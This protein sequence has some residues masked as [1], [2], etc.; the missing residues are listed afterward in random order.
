MLDVMTNTRRATIG[1]PREFDVDEALERAMVVFWEQGYEGASLTDLTAAMGITRTS[2]YAAFGN[3]EGLFRKA[4]DRYSAGPAGYVARALEEPTA[5]EVAA[6]FLHGGVDTTTDP[7]RPHGCLTVQGALAAAPA[8]RAIRDALS[9]WRN[10]A[11][12]RLRDRFQRAKDEGD[13]PP[14]S[15]PAL[16][17]RLVATVASG[18]AVQAAGGAGRDEL[19]RVADA[20]LQSW[21]LA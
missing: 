10:N 1:R 8:D 5:R 7:D 15:D 19:H 2:M 9:D 16:L 13:L 21:P 12:A 6:A 18:I 14:T 17:A 3:K 20:A 4:L 11:C